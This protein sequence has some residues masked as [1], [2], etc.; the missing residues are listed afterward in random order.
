MHFVKSN[1]V[2]AFLVLVAST[3]LISSH[4]LIKQA[5]EDKSLVAST[6]SNTSSAK[7]ETSSSGSVKETRSA[8][9]E[10]YLDKNNKIISFDAPSQPELSQQ[11]QPNNNQSSDLITNEIWDDAQTRPYLLPE[12]VKTIVQATTRFA[13]AQTSVTRH[14]TIDG[15]MSII[16]DAFYLL[17]RPAVLVK[18]MKFLSALLASSLGASLF[19]PELMDLIWHKPPTSLLQLDSHLYGNLIESRAMHFLSSSASNGHF[20]DSEPNSTDS[21]SCHEKAI[22]SLSETM[23]CLMPQTSKALICFFRNNFASSLETIRAH[24]LGRAFAS[25]F[26]DYNCTL[27]SKMRSNN[28]MRK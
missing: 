18:V 20:M 23:D 26:K 27:T 7:A 14:L 4:T 3:R 17:A 12:P 9:I 16:N 6:D 1:L 5:K 10:K 11:Q 25:G 21:Q 2:F 22:R 8:K 28:Q 24:N 15:A 13:L 19:L